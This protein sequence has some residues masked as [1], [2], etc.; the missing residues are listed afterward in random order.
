M[1]RRRTAFVLVAGFCL[2]LLS[3]PVVAEM[4]RGS[5]TQQAGVEVGSGTGWS[6]EGL[7]GWLQSLFQREHGQIV[8]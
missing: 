4:E 3:G 2:A 8:P 5:R 1:R 7:W 6:M